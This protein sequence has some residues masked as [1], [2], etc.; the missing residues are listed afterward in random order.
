[1]NSTKIEPSVELFAADFCCIFYGYCQKFWA[2]MNGWELS[3]NLT[4]TLA[5]AEIPL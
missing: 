1:M 4:Q 2:C 3:S 5:Q